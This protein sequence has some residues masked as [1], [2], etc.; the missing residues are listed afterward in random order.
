MS[1]IART[2]MVRH[3][4]RTDIESLSTITS[5]CTTPPFGE[6]ENYTH[7]AC[8]RLLGHAQN[9]FERINVHYTHIFN[10][11]KKKVLLLM[12]QQLCK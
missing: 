4:V 7:L 9:D 12:A 11:S 6:I 3:N 10:T 2:L 8:V 1:L 5:I